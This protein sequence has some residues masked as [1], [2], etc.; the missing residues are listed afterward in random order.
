MMKKYFVL[1]GFFAMFAILSGCQSKN[2]DCKFN[3]LSTP[4]GQP[5]AHINT[6]SF[7]IHFLGN[8]P[9]M[10]DASL[11]KTFDDFTIEAKRLNAKKVRITN[12]TYSR[13]W[14]AF[15]PFTFILVPCSAEVS[16]DAYP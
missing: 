14:F 8:S 5:I 10:G 13:M 16:G 15:P 12:S 4:F 1:M 2:I 11:R 6:S 7:G 3:S 9:L